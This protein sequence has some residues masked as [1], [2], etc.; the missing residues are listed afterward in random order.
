MGKVRR[1][2]T[3]SIQIHGDAWRCQLFA[4]KAVFDKASDP[5][6]V[7]ETKREE[8]IIVF[9]PEG[10]TRRTAVHELFHAYCSYLFLDSTEGMERS[11]YEEIYAE[12]LDHYWDTIDRQATVIYD[13][14][15]TL[16]V[17]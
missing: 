10:M 16:E 13:N 17:A 7:A 14:M 2:K 3:F 8:K 4:E 9:G 5:G 12:M 6:N 1:R 11:N 15:K